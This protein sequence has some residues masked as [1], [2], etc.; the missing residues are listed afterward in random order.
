VQPSDI[1]DYKPPSDH[2]MEQ[3]INALKAELTDPR[4]ATDYWRSQIN[5]QLDMQLKSEQQAFASRGLDFV[6]KEYL[7]TR[8][9]DRGYSEGFPGCRRN[10]ILSFFSRASGSFAGWDVR[11]RNTLQGRLSVE[12]KLPEKLGALF[13]QSRDKSLF[14]G[15]ISVILLESKGQ[16]DRSA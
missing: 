16:A 14:F 13:H 11:R 5:L 3:D 4:F 1:A 2:L 6:T 7:P 9:S 10:L 12:P 8:L 15:N